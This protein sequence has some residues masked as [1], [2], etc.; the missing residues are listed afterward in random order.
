MNERAAWHGTEEISE[1]EQSSFMETDTRYDAG[2]AC[3]N[4]DIPTLHLVVYIRLNAL[5][6]NYSTYLEII[7]KYFNYLIP[8]PLSPLSP[9]YRGIF[10][11]NG[12]SSR[13]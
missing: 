11:W 7:D 8:W 1:G 4:S 6:N 12:P 5:S 10:P 9:P 13:I 3:T 2:N